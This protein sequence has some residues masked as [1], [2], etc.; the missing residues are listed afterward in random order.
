[1]RPWE[2]TMRIV[3]TGAAGRLGSI[4]RKHLSQSPD[5]EQV[6]ID[7]NN[8]GDPA[9]RLADLATNYT[10]WDELFDGA[11]VVIHLAADPRPEAPWQ[12]V[13]RNNIDVTIN[14][15]RAAATH[16]VRRVIYASTLTTMD[17]YRYNTGPISADWAPR[18]VTFYAI[19]KLIGE[20]IGR[21]FAESHNMSVICLRLGAVQTGVRTPGRGSTLWNRAKWLSKDDL[22]QAIVKAILIK[23]VVFMVLPVISDNESKTWDLSKT[24]TILGYEAKNGVGADPP[25]FFIR[26]RGLLGWLYRRYLDQRWKHYWP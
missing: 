3:I 13:A 2:Q 6:L 11:E 4:V 23:D 18:P 25:Y 22:C 8:H 16:N 5:H 17:G 26:I 15:F 24:C 12:A 10:A 1:M 20:T 14:V 9:I 19:S 21:M 7:C